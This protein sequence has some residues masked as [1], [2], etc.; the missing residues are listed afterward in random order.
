LD[1][2]EDDPVIVVDDSEDEEENIIIN[3][4]VSNTEA[5]PEQPPSSPRFTQLQVLTNEVLL[6]QS[7]KH[8]LEREK[9]KASKLKAHPSFLNMAQINEQLVKS[10]H[11]KLPKLLSTHDFRSSLPTKLKELPSRVGELFDEVKALKTTVNMLEVELPTELKEIPS[12]LEEFTKTVSSVQAK[13]KV[14][15]ALP[16]PPNIATKA[17]NT[18]TQMHTPFLPKSPKGFS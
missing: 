9:A 4:D 14:L 8:K 16:I 7:Q 5:N 11:A 1:S 15:D 2:P 17:I 12:K 10:L 13:L 18:F 6:L 3:D